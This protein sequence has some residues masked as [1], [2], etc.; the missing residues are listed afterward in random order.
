MEAIVTEQGP[1]AAF[2]QLSVGL[3][4][5]SQ[6][7][8]QAQPT[9]SGGFRLLCFGLWA[10]IEQISDRELAKPVDLGVLEK[11][12]VS[13]KWLYLVEEAI[14]RVTQNR[15]RLEYAWFLVVA[16]EGLGGAYATSKHEVEAAVRDLLARIP[17]LYSR[18]LDQGARCE[19]FLQWVQSLCATRKP[20]AECLPEG[21]PKLPVADPYDR[22][23][24]YLA[25]L[26]LASDLVA[27]GRVEHGALVYYGLWCEAR[28]FQ[29][30]RWEP[31]LVTRCLV[32]YLDACT[33]KSVPAPQEIVSACVA[34]ARLSPEEF[35][36][37]PS[38]D[39]T[40]WCRA[41]AG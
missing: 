11:L 9:C 1:M 39:L 31:G 18:T 13:K 34:L 8:R 4:A 16:L 28:E 27:R 35:S 21:A 24:R 38:A 32:G 40:K 41:G 37:H 26:D 20:E 17:D 12:Q 6:I 23:G 33:Y 5:A 15:Q 19:S 2:R 22:R 30:E 14:S 25:Q 3:L 36:K 7:L 10:H 29:L